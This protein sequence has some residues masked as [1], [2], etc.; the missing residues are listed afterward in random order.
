MIH[1]D[2]FYN[3]TELE[4]KFRT[5]ADYPLI[6]LD[7]DTEPGGLLT[8]KKASKCRGRFSDPVHFSFR[9]IFPGII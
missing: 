3:G 5:G 2:I 8:G 1:T 7:A 9:Y 6:I 4:E